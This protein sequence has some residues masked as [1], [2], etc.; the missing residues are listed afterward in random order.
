MCLGSTGQIKNLLINNQ[1]MTIITI[2]TLRD[3]SWY[4][5]DCVQSILTK[6][7]HEALT[8]HKRVY[9]GILIRND[10]INGRNIGLLTYECL[11]ATTF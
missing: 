11:T 9:A 1:S 8:E 2:M 3:D 6:N 10:F 7:L 4:R 5:V